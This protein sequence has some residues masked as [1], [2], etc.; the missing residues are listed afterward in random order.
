M[1][2]IFAVVLRRDAGPSKSRHLASDLV[3]GLGEALDVTAGDAGNGYPTVLGGI[4]GVLFI[5]RLCYKKQVCSNMIHAK[6]ET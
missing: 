4:H 3:D 6:Q 5:V 2:K 1:P